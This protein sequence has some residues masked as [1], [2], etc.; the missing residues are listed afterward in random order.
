MSGEQVLAPGGEL[1]IHPDGRALLA[2]SGAAPCCGGNGCPPGLSTDWVSPPPEILCGYSGPN[3]PSTIWAAS[4][5]ELPANTHYLLMFE[6]EAAIVVG[7]FSSYGDIYDCGVL[8]RVCVGLGQTE[9]ARLSMPR[10][11]TYT[12]PC[13]VNTVNTGTHYAVC[14]V[15]TGSQARQLTV[16]WTTGNPNFRDAN[17]LRVRLVSCSTYPYPPVVHT[18]EELQTALSGGFSVGTTKTRTQG[19]LGPSLDFG[20]GAWA[21]C[22]WADHVYYANRAWPAVIVHKSAWGQGDNPLLELFSDNVIGN[23]KFPGS[24]NPPTPALWFSPFLFRYSIPNNVPPDS[25]TFP[26]T[27][28]ALVAQSTPAS[29]PNDLYCQVFQYPNIWGGVR[30]NSVGTNYTLFGVVAPVLVPGDRNLG[31]CAEQHITVSNARVVP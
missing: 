21:D 10:S 6:V 25:V 15:S 5:G 9:V 26:I 12:N 24:T 27:S 28:W 23:G 11:W 1:L 16:G 22:W 18:L 2:E 8:W 14:L 20:T 3:P 17:T 31:H 4:L 7:A 29:I 13:S 30:L 19:N